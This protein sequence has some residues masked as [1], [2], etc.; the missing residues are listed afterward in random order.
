[1]CESIF[2]KK[3][4]RI[5]IVPPFK[6]LNCVVHEP[7]CH[8]INYI[9]IPLMDYDIELLLISL[10]PLCIYYHLQVI[11]YCMLFNYWFYNI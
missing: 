3:S 9:C 10:W 7:F 4:M 5:A 8:I 11:L 2:C 6:P 1:M